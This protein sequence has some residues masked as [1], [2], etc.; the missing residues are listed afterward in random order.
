LKRGAPCTSSESAEA[1]GVSGAAVRPQLADLVERG[2]VEQSWRSTGGRGRPAKLWSLTERAIGLFADRHGELTVELLA[3]LRAAL[4]DEAL[5]AVLA[6]RDRAQQA[7]LECAMA[8]ITDIAT[9]A[10]RLAD[11]RSR[12]GY[13]AEVVPDGSDLLLVEHHCPIC[14]AAE[15]CEGLCRYELD[16]FRRALGAEV[17]VERTQHLLA[18]DDR[19]VYRIRTRSGSGGV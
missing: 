2:L 14:A 1:L 17:E 16:M 4:G 15:A 11:H 5:D 7:A 10:R 8:G 9:R 6:E 18:G 3:A 12:Q 19:C 13:M